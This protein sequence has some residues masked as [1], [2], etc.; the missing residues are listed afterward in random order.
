MMIEP[1]KKAKDNIYDR[2][3]ILNLLSRVIR[4]LWNVGHLSIRSEIFCCYLLLI[5]ECMITVNIFLPNLNY[6]TLVHLIFTNFAYLLNA[7]ANRAL[8]Y[9]RFEF[10]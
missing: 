8:L 3:I 2:F 10:L 7:N 6:C 4:S 5:C 9:A 1:L